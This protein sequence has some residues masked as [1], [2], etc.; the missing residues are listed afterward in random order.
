MFSFAKICEMYWLEHTYCI[1]WV[2]TVDSHKQYTNTR[3]A[4]TKM[5]SR[6]HGKKQAKKEKTENEEEEVDCCKA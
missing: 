6:K 4:K 2:V 3:K 5:W 1:G